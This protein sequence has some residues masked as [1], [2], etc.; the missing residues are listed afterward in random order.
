MANTWQNSD[1]LFLKFGTANA[2]PSTV[3]EY[4]YDG[5]LHMI[6]QT[7]TLT[8]VGSAGA[9]ASGADQVSFPANAK[10]EK[11]DI[12]TKT[13][14]TSGGAAT[15]DLGLISRDRSTEIDFNGFVAAIPKTSIDTAGETTTVQVGGTYA[16]ALVGTTVG[17]SPGYLSANY[18]T[19]AFTAGVLLVR[20][21]YRFD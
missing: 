5:P 3:G 9:V 12:V 1:G 10:I 18:G 8:T 19:A 17:T 13:A 2:G 7:L 6:E 20:Y 11:I 21:Y 16:G 14:A 4:C 15:L